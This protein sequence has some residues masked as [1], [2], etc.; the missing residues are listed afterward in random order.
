M[1][2]LL[3]KKQ[4]AINAHCKQSVLPASPLWTGRLIRQNR[5]VA[6]SSH[7]KHPFP[8]YMLKMP[9]VFKQISSLKV[10]GF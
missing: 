6:K 1:R 7:Q 4:L 8:R 5:M 2:F 3:L 9:F 10:V